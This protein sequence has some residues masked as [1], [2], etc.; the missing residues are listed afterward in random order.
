MKPAW[1]LM[2]ALIVIKW[3][4]KGGNLPVLTFLKTCSLCKPVIEF[5]LK[6]VT[7]VVKCI[8]RRSHT[9]AHTRAYVCRVIRI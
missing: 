7:R 3:T 1:P 2:M 6:E 8:R 9:L 5:V 4:R